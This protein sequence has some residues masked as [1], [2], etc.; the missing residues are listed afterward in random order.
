MKSRFWG[1]AV[2]ALTSAS[3]SGCESGVPDEGNEEETGELSDEI[4]QGIE[5]TGDMLR[6]VVQVQHRNGICSGTLISPQLVLFAGHCATY[7]QG[8]CDR[9]TFDQDAS[10]GYRVVIPPLGSANINDPA[11]TIIKLDGIQ[12]HPAFT[13]EDRVSKCCPAGDP[14]GCTFCARDSN[15]VIANVTNN[16]RHDV[17]VGHLSQPVSGITPSKVLFRIGPRLTSIGRYPVAVS[18]LVGR[19]VIIAGTSSTTNFPNGSFRAFAT[20]QIFE[21]AYPTFDDLAPPVDVLTGAACTAP[22]QHNFTLGKRL[23][24]THQLGRT[25]GG[26]SVGGD[27]GGPAFLNLVS[28]G[29][30][31]FP[32]AELASTDVLVAGMSSSGDGTAVGGCGTGGSAYTPSWD[33]SYT[34]TPSDGGPVKVVAG[35]NGSFVEAR[36][37]DFDA[38]GVFDA[39]DNCPVA[40]NPTQANCNAHAEDAKLYPRRGDV[41]DPI[42]CARSVARAPTTT[43][44]HQSENAGFQTKTWKFVQDEIDVTPMSSRFYGNGAGQGK[45]RPAVA[46]G[47]VPTQYRFC[48]PDLDNDVYCDGQAIDDSYADITEGTPDPSRPYHKARMIANPGSGSGQDNE[49]LSYVNGAA[50][51]AR[52]WRY[53]ADSALWEAQGWITNVSDDAPNCGA[54]DQCYTNL[55]GRFWS[56][57]A[58][59]KGRFADRVAAVNDPVIDRA[60]PTTGFRVNNA[61]LGSTA[62]SAEVVYTFTKT[63]AFN[64]QW[65]FLDVEGNV[66]LASTGTSNFG[67]AKFDTGGLHP[68]LTPSVVQLEL[69]S[70]ELA[71]LPVMYVGG[72]SIVT[73]PAVGVPYVTERRTGLQGSASTLAALDAIL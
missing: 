15:G 30:S 23:K 65:L 56:H 3:V 39:D 53:A 61:G 64:K 62:A 50:P 37:K 55:D 40:P 70:G 10:N 60:P 21:M 71:T 4:A 49:P 42:P 43:L 18:S 25:Q 67:I 45:L 48:Q 47:S 41:C 59:T 8:G 27:S 54:Y 16:K 68:I 1:A 31:A 6:Q 17:A 57:A 46:I 35:T 34:S 22:V 66:V 36:L 5:D 73:R 69:R 11:S 12:L 2:V 44:L 24:L 13:R 26:C 51:V 32:V 63:A 14:V 19:N 38:D 28:L 33:F 72:N 20:S 7:L 58:T 29:G 52:R 9:F